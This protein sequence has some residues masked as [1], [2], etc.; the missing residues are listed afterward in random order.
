MV[1]VHD[2]HEVRRIG[3]FG[4]WETILLYIVHVQLEPQHKKP[5]CVCTTRNITII[6]DT[7]SSELQ[8]LD[9]KALH[10]PMNVFYQVTL[11]RAAESSEVLWIVSDGE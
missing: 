7:Y 11:P 8:L 2:Q 9:V 5:A 10:V 4:N 3:R 1:R 6:M